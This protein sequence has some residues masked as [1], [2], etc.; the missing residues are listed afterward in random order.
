MTRFRSGRARWLRD[1]AGWVGWAWLAVWLGFSAAPNVAQGQGPNR[2]ATKFYPDFSDTADALL[3]NAASHAR[4]GQWAETVEIYQRVIQQFGDKVAR[5][6]KDDP[7]ADPKGDSI[8]FVDLRQFCQRRLAALPPEARVLYRARVDDQAERWYRQG[9]AERN[10]PLL[11]R[12]I[13]QAF[14]SSWGDDA[15]E[16]LGDLAFQDG[17]LDEALSMYRQLVP[18]R[19]GDRTGLIYPDPSVD[20]ARVA[21]KKLLCQAALGY[22][23]PTAADLAAFAAAYPGATGKL[24]G[25]EGPLL[26]IVTEALKNDQ[27][28]PTAEP[29]GRWPTFAGAPT[30]S[31]V[32]PG[33]IDVGSLQWR[34]EL[35]PVTSN[36]RNF[37]RSRPFPF[38]TAP[39]P[40][41]RKL[42]YHPIVLGD[43]VVVCDENQIVAYNLN[44][45]PSDMAGSPGMIKEL[46]KHREDH[47]GAPPSAPRLAMGVPRFTLTAFGDRIYARMGAT[48]TPLGPFGRGGG[49]AAPSAIVAVD[50]STEGKVLW[51]VLSTEVALPQRPADAN[52]NN[53]RLGFEGTPVADARCVYAAMTDR[54]ELTSTYVVAL[55]AETGV[56]RWIRYL[57]ASTDA[58]IIGGGFGMGFAPL[59]TDL[60]HRLLSLDGPTIYFQTNLGAVAALDAETGGIRWVATYPREDRDD[61]G[62]GRDRDLNPAIVHDGLVIVA[63]D[64]T[65]AI[66][67]FDA[68]SGRLVWKSD[69]LP[70]EVK[71]AHLLGVA[72]GRLIATGDRVLLF[73]VKTGKL[74]HTWPDGGR[75]NEG[76]GRGLLAGDKIYWPTRT[77]IHVLDQTSGV[78]TEPP[79]KLQEPFQTTGGN[80]AVGDGYLIVAQ[81]DQMVVFCQNSRL[82]ERYRDEITRDPE[83][84]SNY[85]RLAQAA[86]ATGQETLAL[87]KLAETLQRARPSETIDGVLLRDAARDHYYHLLMKLGRKARSNRDF[88]QAAERFEAA[89]GAARTDRERLAARL[90]LSEVQLDWGRPKAAVVTL[91]QLLFDDRLRPLNID[92]DDGHRTIRADLLITDRLGAILRAQGRELYAEYDRQAHGLLVHGQEERDPRLLEEVGQSYPVAQVVPAALLAL[93][94]LNESAH[95]PVEAAHAYKRLLVRADSDALRAGA[96][97]G[98]GRAYEAQRLWV[99][100]RDAYAEA[101]GRFPDTLLEGNLSARQVITA[102]LSRPPFDRLMSDCTEPSLPVPLVRHWERSLEGPVHPI[103]AEGVPPSAESSR[104]FLAQGTTLRPVDPASG[105]TLWTAELDAPPVWVGYLADKVIA[106]TETRI[107]ALGLDQGALQWQYDAGSAEAARRGA[108]PFARPEPEPPATPSGAGAGAGPGRLHHFRIVGGRIFCLRGT[109]ELVAFDGDTGLVDWSFAP[110]AGTINPNLWIGP[111]RIV[112]QVSKPGA[113]LVLETASG[114][115]RAEYPADED[116]EWA[117]CPVPI[118]DDHVVLVPDRRTVALFDLR[119]GVNSWIFRESLELP[120]HGAPR[121]L[122]G[123]ERLIVIHDGTNAIRLDPA[124]GDKVW[125]QS[126]PLGIEDLS[127]RPESTVLDSERFYWV[128]DQ[129][130]K[131]AAL[132]DGVMTWTQHLT[133]PESSWALALSERCVMAY[134]VP[135][136]IQQGGDEIDGLSLVFRRRDTGGLVQRLFFPVTLSDVAVRL[137]P[138]GALV[139]TRAGL[140]SLGE[141]RE[142]PR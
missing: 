96:L 131:S 102:R 111:Q 123:A 82:I 72:K 50:R 90:V 100:A 32:V 88:A 116:Q 11:R 56:P 61:G 52:A 139:A 133:G 20:L 22:M 98:L 91:Q 87:E 84:A 14:C 9:A 62:G 16:L 121:L 69:A 23:P 70:G 129:T 65:S 45:R 110:L 75:A 124:T 137:A 54:R 49:M 1:Q 41:D 39:I 107:V 120:K 66:Y 73:D 95:R 21:A 10:R 113:L 4:D 85:Y 94:R 101:L 63:P 7:T 132:K 119:R 8:L 81:I 93:G 33:A 31:K 74:L 12:I 57:G 80:L 48:G 59:A 89:G 76:F 108:N 83:K 140:W 42:A 38:P 115:R 68:G 92:T 29:D 141:R 77:E 112:L 130:L 30:R 46:W 125:A 15:L 138:H 135:A 114:R 35:V 55:D 28:A 34:V 17:R 36:P 99:P 142:K 78:P 79:I 117:R 2:T 64:D 109:R 128:S 40:E 24:A 58:Q 122:G 19:P 67:A 53:R 106:T 18:D 126:L 26:Q 103:V 134:P 27:L 13:E 97:W 5:L 43:Q 51:K 86:E 127:E 37:P 105:S 60:G 6:P 136:P 47:E 44:D 3:R 71:L 25:R 118:D 104:I